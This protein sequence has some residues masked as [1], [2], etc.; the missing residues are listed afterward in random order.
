MPL[1]S[2]RLTLKDL[3]AG[4][5]ELTPEELGKLHFGES[6]V[7]RMFAS[8]SSAKPLYVSG[9]ANANNE[10]LISFVLYPLTALEKLNLETAF[11]DKNKINSLATAMGGSSGSQPA[12]ISGADTIGEKSAGVTT[13]SGGTQP[14]RI[15]FIMAT[16]GSALQFLIDL[17]PADQQ[18]KINTIELAKI[19][20]ARLTAALGK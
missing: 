8:A 3:P 12:Q 6:D 16:R 13:V 9:F 4:F 17:H 11:S 15:Q 18:A 2:T 5:V 7:A 19:L 20:D 1:S 10:Y 14:M